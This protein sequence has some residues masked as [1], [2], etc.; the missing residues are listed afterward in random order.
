[1]GHKKIAFALGSGFYRRENRHTG[2]FYWVRHSFITRISSC[3]VSL[4][5]FREARWNYLISKSP[6][7]VEVERKFILV[8]FVPVSLIKVF[9]IKFTLP[10][11]SGA[12]PD[13]ISSHQEC[14]SPQPLHGTFFASEVVERA[15]T[16]KFSIRLY[17]NHWDKVHIEL[18]DPQ[19]LGPKN[20]S[21]K[22]K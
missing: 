10:S 17:C 15:N 2:V 7:Q 16:A 13:C 4:D 1:M 18:L 12:S 14:K 19:H 8:L 6:S 21:R 20:W 3:C 11:L 9:F 22:H 5:V